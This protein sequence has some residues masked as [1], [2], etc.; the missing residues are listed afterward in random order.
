[1]KKWYVYFVNRFG[2]KDVHCFEDDEVQAR[3][4]A[5]QVN[6]RVVQDW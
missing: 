3:F 5:E 2:R 6:G 1:M 4:F